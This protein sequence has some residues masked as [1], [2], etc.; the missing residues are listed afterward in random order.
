MEITF[1]IKVLLICFTKDD[2]GGID[3]AWFE[4]RDLKWHLGYPMT[5]QNIKLALDQH[6]LADGVDYAL[7]RW[8]PA[9]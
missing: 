6:P 9:S 8:G 7:Y 1:T 3:K 5:E 2:T 4:S